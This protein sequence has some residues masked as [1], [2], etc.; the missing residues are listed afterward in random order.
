MNLALVANALAWGGFFGYLALRL[1][2]GLLGVGFCL[3]G[4]L[5]WRWKR[6]ASTVA[7]GVAKP[8]NILSLLLRLTLYTL[9]FAALLRFGDDLA[10]HR[11]RSGDA[12]SGAL[13]FFLAAGALVLI[14]LPATR[15]RLLHYWKMSHEYDYAD[16]RRRTKMLN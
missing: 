13:P 6:L 9:V 1:F 15:R 7:T 5:L 2:D 14:R 3:H 16:R 4:L 11:L 12:G 10:L 8:E